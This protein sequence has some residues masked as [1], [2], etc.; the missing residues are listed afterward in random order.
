MRFYFP[1]LSN[2]NNLHIP[3]ILIQ[4]LF[5]K[6]LIGLNKNLE[7]KNMHQPT[8]KKKSQTLVPYFADFK[9]ILFCK[10]NP[11]NII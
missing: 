5:S 7:T 6:P 3:E 10:N 9:A 2:Y 1:K 4:N 8:Q 11:K